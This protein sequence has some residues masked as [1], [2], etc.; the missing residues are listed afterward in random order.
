MSGIHN[1]GETADEKRELCVN[2]GMML[3]IERKSTIKTN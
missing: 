3:Q 2:Q 1:E